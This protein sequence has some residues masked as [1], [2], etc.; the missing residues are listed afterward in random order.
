MMRNMVKAQEMMTM[1]MMMKT[2][3]HVYTLQTELT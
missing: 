2:I 1:M 3:E